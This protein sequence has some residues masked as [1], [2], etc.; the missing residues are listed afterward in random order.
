MHLIDLNAPNA[1]LPKENELP[2]L[3]HLAYGTSITQGYFASSHSLCYAY[4]TADA[5]GADLTN[6][7]CSGNAYCEP[8]LGDYLADLDYDFATFELSVNMFNGGLTLEEYS[9]RISCFIKK[10]ADKSKGR[11]I[12]CISFFPYYYD[13]GI[14]HP[15]RNPKGDPDMFRDALKDIVSSLN[16]PN[17]YF[18]SGKEL[19]P[20]FTGLCADL[21]HP[22]NKGMA[23]IANNLIS[24]MKPKLKE[25]YK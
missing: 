2:K 4:L 12:F 3:K 23:E 22:S 13:I 24:F 6:F 9:D 1:R 17:F 5:L 16:L 20:D 7:G 25:Y 18:I 11:P 21:L 8:E 10:I 14:R 15:D 19:M